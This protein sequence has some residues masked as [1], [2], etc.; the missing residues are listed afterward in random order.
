ML[1][2]IIYLIGGD[3]TSIYLTLGTDDRKDP[4]RV[5]IVNTVVTTKA[6]RAGT[7]SFEIQ[8]L[9]QERTTIRTVG[10]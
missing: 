4:I 1:E 7:A 10:A 9:S 5:T 8:K 6:T 2:I 3:T